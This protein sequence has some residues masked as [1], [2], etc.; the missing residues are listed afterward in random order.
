MHQLLDSNRINKPP[1]ASN[2]KS[3]MR[4]CADLV[5]LPSGNNR[6]MQLPR[7]SMAAYAFRPPLPT[8]T[9][10][11]PI[12]GYG[13]HRREERNGWP[14]RCR[15]AC[16]STPIGRADVPAVDNV[17]RGRRFATMPGSSDESISRKA[18]PSARMVG[19]L[20]RCRRIMRAG[21]AT[22][23]HAHVAAHPVEGPEA[24]VGNVVAG[25][26]H[27]PA[28][29][30]N[31]HVWI[32]V[33]ALKSALFVQLSNSFSQIAN[34]ISHGQTLEFDYALFA[35]RSSPCR[36]LAIRSGCRS[37]HSHGID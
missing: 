5:G 17:T 22:R 33:V 3:V 37:R 4:V 15:P 20:Y 8:S 19:F 9:D 11:Q 29:H 14:F 23:L 21:V 16:E 18:W 27:A 7:Y 6:T 12:S 10:S 35:D 2:Q 13:P 30:R 1:Q 24:A 26:R 28:C 36:C 25:H 31:P 32:A 34:E